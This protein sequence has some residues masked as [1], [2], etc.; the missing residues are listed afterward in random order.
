MSPEFGISW[1]TDSMT[2]VVTGAAAYINRPVRS[3]QR[4]IRTFS[5]SHS[6]TSDSMIFNY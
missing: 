2:E 4:G 1:A 6:R 3:M 5:P